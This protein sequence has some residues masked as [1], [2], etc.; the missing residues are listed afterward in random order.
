MSKNATGTV[1]GDE[2]PRGASLFRYVSCELPADVK[3]PLRY[4][5]CELPTDEK[6]GYSQPRKVLG[7]ID[8]EDIRKSKP[9]PTSKIVRK[10]PVKISYSLPGKV[11]ETIDNEHI[12]KSE[13]SPASKLVRRVAGKVS[14]SLSEKVL[15]TI[16]DEDIDK[17]KPSKVSELVRKVAR[18]MPNSIVLVTS[19]TS[20][21]TD[22]PDPEPHSGQAAPSP[23][24][25]VQPS[26]HFRGM[27]VSSF[28]MLSMNPDPCITFNIKRPSKTLDA[29]QQSG[30]F[31]VHL[32]RGTSSGAQI[33]RNFSTSWERRWETNEKWKVVEGASDDGTILPVVV[34][35]GVKRILECVYEGAVKV[36]DHSIVIGRVVEVHGRDDEGMMKESLRNG[37]CYMRG[38]YRTVGKAIQISSTN[39]S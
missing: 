20:T 25:E 22:N 14:S 10:V 15:E 11:M 36:M 24:Q 17:S 21:S 18:Y 6:I 27:T 16:D 9:S 5:C 2:L 30:R 3:I 1:Y 12:G 39:G 13:P 4:V 8:N 34:G 19:S 28:T 23:G 29:I 32:L 37:L 35:F 38:E 33:A 26:S 7:R 31:L